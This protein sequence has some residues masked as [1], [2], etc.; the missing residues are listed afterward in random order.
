[1]RQVQSRPKVI[2][3]SAYPR[4]LPFHFPLWLVL[5]VLCD[6]IQFHSSFLRVEYPHAFQCFQMSKATEEFD[7]IDRTSSNCSTIATP[8]SKVRFRYHEKRYWLSDAWSRYLRKIFVKLTYISKFKS[9]CFSTFYMFLCN[10]Y[11]DSGNCHR[12]FKY[13]C[14]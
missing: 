1:M 4:F 10:F 7:L 3:I 12:A 13:Y 8:N 6:F 11:C 5:K 2:L 14:C 9:I